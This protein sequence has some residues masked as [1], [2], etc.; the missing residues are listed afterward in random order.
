MS[1]LLSTENTMYVRSLSDRNVVLGVSLNSD[2]SIVS[3]RDGCEDWTRVKRYR[4]EGFKLHIGGMQQI[5]LDEINDENYYL[6]DTSV[7]TML[8]YK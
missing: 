6:L 8:C 3:Y 5:P 4:A 2:N 7:F 1:A